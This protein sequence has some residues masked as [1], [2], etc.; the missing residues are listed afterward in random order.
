V[1]PFHFNVF[2]FHIGPHNLKRPLPFLQEAEGDEDEWD[3]ED[4]GNAS[5]KVMCHLCCFGENEGSTKAAKMLPCKLCNKR[6]HRNCLKSW[7][8][9]R[10]NTIF[11]LLLSLQH[12]FI[13]VHHLID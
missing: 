12:L 8:E 6:Y 5:V 4:Q 13:L 9:H 10:G 11:S 2:Y 1:L 3:R 7:G